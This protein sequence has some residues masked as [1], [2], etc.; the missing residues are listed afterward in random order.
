MIATQVEHSYGAS[1]PEGL[2]PRHTLLNAFHRAAARRMCYVSAP[3][4]AGK[5]VSTM[6]WLADSGRKSTLLSARG[7]YNSCAEFYLALGRGLYSLQPSNREVERILSR[8]DFGSSPVEFAECLVSTLT[9]DGDL[10]AVVIDDFHLIDNEEIHKSLP[11]ILAALPYCFSSFVLSRK[12]PP[13]AWG[14][15]L[16]QGRATAIGE[17]DL[18]FSED[19]IGEYFKNQGIPLTDN[20]VSAVHAMTGGWAMGVNALALSGSIRFGAG[21]SKAIDGYLQGHVWERWPEESRTFLLKT[22]IVE[23]M[24]PELCDRLTGRQDS[25]RVLSELCDAKMFI[26]NS[27]PG[28]YRCHHLFQGFLR[29]KLEESPDI[30]MAGLFRAAAGYYQDMD[31]Q[32]EALRFSAMGRD[33]DGVE[34]GMLRLYTYTTT[35]GN[36]VAEHA[37]RLGIYMLDLARGEAVQDNPYLLI[38]YTWYHFLMGEPDSMH[39]YLDLIYANFDRLVAK[40]GAFFDLS[41]LISALDSRKEPTGIALELD[42]AESLPTS[43]GTVQS[44]T[45]T[46]NMPFFHRGFRDFSAYSLDMENSIANLVRAFGAMVGQENCDICVNL[47]RAGILYEQNRLGAASEIATRV[48]ASL[49]PETHAELKLAALLLLGVIHLADDEADEYEDQLNALKTVLERDSA[50]YL[51]PNLL[52][53]ETK[54]KLMDAGKAA[55]REWLARYF[56]TRP[57]RPE[58]YKIFQHF[59]TARALIV[60]NRTDEALRLLARLRAMGKAYRRQRDEGEAAVLEA[61]VLWSRGQREDALVAVKEALVLMQDFDFI[62]VFADEGSAITPLLKHVQTEVESNR[63]Q[64]PLRREHVNNAYLAAYATSKTRKGITWNVHAGPVK[65]TRQQSAVLALLSK[66][67]RQKQIAEMTGL[68]L[69]TIKSHTYVLYKKLDVNNAA[70]AIL[71]ARDMGLLEAES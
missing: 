68:S 46:E 28:A 57:E 50:M 27:R 34:A 59:T 24:T 5:T 15:L 19:E 39:H 45:L 1:L 16:A 64:G 4:G 6:L 43:D 44:V 55:A 35:Q 3:G 49:K 51:L 37:E 13:E 30:D 69:P 53:V 21:E 52:A 60:L 25:A 58:F 65:L 26:V 12:A 7:A 29:S 48:A 71:K 40:H 17:S 38:N 33:Y 2:A 31:M 54:Y 63:Y 61:C 11:L 42:G 14:G 18:P 41:L 67:H 8:S 36:S 56:V 23:E 32:Y 62:R 10:Y 70:D 22:C 20:E 66:G 9:D 47:I